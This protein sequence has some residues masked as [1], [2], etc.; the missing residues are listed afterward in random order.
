M[1]EWQP[2]PCPTGGQRGPLSP[3]RP[4]QPL[5]DRLGCLTPE[6]SSLIRRH[7]VDLH[8]LLENS[9]PT[10]DFHELGDDRGA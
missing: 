9:V 3:D 1:G 2:S 5:C 8:D 10:I 4:I 7:R 6:A